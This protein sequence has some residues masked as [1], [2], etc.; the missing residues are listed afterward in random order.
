MSADLDPRDQLTERLAALGRRPVDTAVQSEHLTA[1]A[2]VRS[3]SAFRTSLVGRLKIGAGVMAGFLIGAT[4]L[5]TAGAMGPLQPIAADVVEAV[6]PV[7]VPRGKADEAKAKAK[8]AHDVDGQGSIGTERDW[9]GCTPGEGGEFAGNRG[10]Y[11]KQER[12]NGA[13]ALAAAKASNCGK[14]LN[15]DADEDVDATEAPKAGGAKGATGANQGQ[16]GQGNGNSAGQGSADDA[17]KPADVGKPADAGKPAETGAKPG[18]VPAPAATE[19]ANANAKLP[20]PRTPGAP[21]EDSTGTD[22]EAEAETEP[23][24]SDL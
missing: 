18:T 21:A 15:D 2:G 19:K 10:Q 9:A 17:G 13:D 8:A 16:N 7:D 23:A 12:A 11:L 24:G 3:G 4:G 6:A 1:I 20:A 22:S 5:T 14:P